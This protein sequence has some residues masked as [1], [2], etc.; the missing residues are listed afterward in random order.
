MKKLFALLSVALA[1]CATNTGIVEIGD[2]HYMYA[3]QD[4]MAYSGATVKV[5]MIKEARAFCAKQGK[6]MSLLG[7]ASQDYA[8][9]SS[10]ASAEIQFQCV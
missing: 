4:W 8:M 7:Q 1:A 10:A 5:E 3:N 9:Y 6:K 2:N